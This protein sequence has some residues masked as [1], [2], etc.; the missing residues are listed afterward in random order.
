MKFVDKL[1]VINI[2]NHP[3]NLSLVNSSYSN[4]IYIYNFIKY[5]LYMVNIWF[6][7]N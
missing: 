4:Y 1:V 2:V 7:Y 5:D 6:I 3:L